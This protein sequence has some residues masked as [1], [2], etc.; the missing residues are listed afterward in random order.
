MYIEVEKYETVFEE[1][2]KCLNNKTP[3]IVIG[4]IA[5][6][7]ESLKQFGPKVVK[8]G[9]FGKSLTAL[10]EHKD[11][12]IREEAKQ[13][14]IEMFRWSKD[15]IKPL[16]QSIKPVLMNELDEEFNKVRDEKPRPTRCLRSEQIPN[17]VE[18]EE[19]CDN[20]DG[21]VQSK[22]DEPEADPFDMYEPAEIL[23]K[24]PSD[25]FEKVE[26]KKWQDR[27]EAV[28]SLSN[29]ICPNPKLLPGEYGDIVK[30][31]KKLVGK[32][33]NVVVV[34][35]AAK[36]L[37]D[38]AGRLRKS[39]HPYAHSCVLVV[40]EKFKEKKQTVI[41]N[42]R[43]AIDAIMY[44]SSLESILEDVISALDNKNPQVR[45][46]SASFVARHC[47]SVNPSA[48][49]HK[50]VL[51]PLIEALIK[52]LNYN[53]PTVR[54]ASAEALGTIMK[55]MGEKSMTPYLGD[56]DSLKMAKIKESFD[57][58]EVKYTAPISQPQAKAIRPG[59]P[60]LAQSSR[61]AG[62]QP[63]TSS[64]SSSSAAISAYTNEAGSS[65]AP[66]KKINAKVA[67]KKTGKPE[68]EVKQPQ[69]GKL[70]TLSKSNSRTGSASTLSSKTDSQSNDG[71]AAPLLPVNN[72]KEQRIN[73]E[74]A[75][76]VLKWNFT[77]PREEFFILLKEQ[78][79][80]ANWNDSLVTN[81]FHSNFKFHIKAIESLT[82]FLKEGNVEATFCSADLILKWFAL[83]FFDTNPSVIIKALE[84][85]IKLFEAY[86]EADYK[87]SEQEASSFIPYLIQKSGD[88]KDI[89]RQ[90]VH[91]I[92]EILKDIYSP[93]RLFT[94][95]IVGLT[96][97]N[98]RQRATCLDE[99]SFLISSYGINICQ[100]SPADALKAI[101]KQI[102]DKDKGVRNA[103]LDCAVSAYQIEGEKVLKLIG[104]I[105]DKDMAMLEERIKRKRP[106]MN[107][108]EKLLPKVEDE[109]KI[110]DSALK[111]I[112]SDTI[113]R[114]DQTMPRSAVKSALLRA[115]SPARVMEDDHV[116]GIQNAR[117]ISAPGLRTQLR[118][119][120]GHFTPPNLPNSQ[121][122]N[123]NT[124][125]I[126]KQR[127]VFN[128]PLSSSPLSGPDCDNMM[129]RYNHT[130][131]EEIP[132]HTPRFN[133]TG[134]FAVNSNNGNSNNNDK[135][136]H[137]VHNMD[138]EENN[139]N[140]HST[141]ENGISRRLSIEKRPT[142]SPKLIE[143]T[144]IP[145]DRSSKMI[146]NY[147]FQLLTV[148][149]YSAVH[150]ANQIIEV[151]Q[152]PDKAQLYFSDKVDHLVMRCNLQHKY[153]LQKHLD[154]P[155]IP[156]E[157]IVDFFK[158][159]N[160]ILGA[161]FDHPNLRR[162]I[163]RDVLKEVIGSLITLLLDDRINHLP[164]SAQLIKSENQL[165]NAIITYADPTNMLSAL[166]QL[167]QDWLLEKQHDNKPIELVM[168]CLWKMSRALGVILS[169]LCVDK[170]LF[171]VH[172]F[173]SQFPPD[174]WKS[175]SGFENDVPMR[176]IKTVVYLLVKHSGD[177][178]FTH[179]TMIPD[180][181]E[182]DLYLYIDKAHRKIRAERNSTSGPNELLKS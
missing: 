51:V 153:L 159:L 31:L 41:I 129:R 158:L 135:D 37:A 80:A 179:L 118:D 178:I 3:K 87:L 139:E 122:R 106:M 24:V 48:W 66:P 97:K 19:I 148:D 49:G 172:C 56:V 173:F 104:S 167:L 154:D 96:S 92:L 18:E 123:F 60:K 42:L 81:C 114:S 98:S 174:F 127:P 145:T 136:D 151:L 162:L 113:L 10:L 166:I 115:S 108:A 137:D 38:L 76:K 7:R 75:L 171:D 126:T 144:P 176:T 165:A 84:Y 131:S 26:S 83:R 68:S 57:K 65:S 141:P 30:V 52:D 73:D 99:L 152:Q 4:A 88:S 72:M 146:G 112:N 25:F 110:R 67:V 86:R 23:S 105:P 125:T 59:P 181:K 132:N 2:S 169:D 143:F 77:T 21:P 33:A 82:D 43:E 101:G 16:I 64:S 9:V 8:M 177:D 142:S 95:V 130:V 32:D 175:E 22:P 28:E 71:F 39:F 157:D 147:V 62:Q 69:P 140:M 100:P 134:T 109:K 36:C 6:I 120:E 61:N 94:F 117:A 20:N 58:A 63:P 124:G 11:P 170:I 12:N 155:N 70:K 128:S 35:L 85:L 54:D 111:K 78:M 1:L 121:R 93:Q 13:L 89:F 79:I 163:T 138:I 74:K 180:A 168:K 50:K 27:K 17:E 150:T 107:V 40:L 119:D 5:L 34:G 15:A 90:R 14:T 164:E 55:V 91:E 149:L 29:L 156:D 53:D 161:I 182:T 160:L 103:A 46:E 44:S 47:A 133:R 45:T 102:G 116:N